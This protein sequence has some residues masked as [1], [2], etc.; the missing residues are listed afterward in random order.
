M[1]DIK[2]MLS[3]N[4]LRYQHMKKK[5]NSRNFRLNNLSEKFLCTHNDD[6]GDCGDGEGWNEGK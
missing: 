1:A 5:F 6:G 2:L 4:Y 3:V